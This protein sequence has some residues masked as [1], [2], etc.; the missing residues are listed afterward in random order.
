VVSSTAPTGTGAHHSGDPITSTIEVA[1]GM[2]TSGYCD[3]AE[4]NSKPPMPTLPQRLPAAPA[5]LLR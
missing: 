4:G 2:T 3:L 5:M 1:N